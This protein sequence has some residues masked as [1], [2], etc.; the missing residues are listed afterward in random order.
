MKSAYERFV[1]PLL[2]AVD[3][4]T[5]H[6]LTIASL[7]AASHIDLALRSLSV[8]QP[9][10]KP[11]RLFGVNFQN[12]VGLAAGLDLGRARIRLH[13]DRDRD[14]QSATW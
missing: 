9:P 4:E 8:F 7:T 12:P 10:A 11:K 13:R 2:F 3:P 5:A 6:R 14:R 1:R